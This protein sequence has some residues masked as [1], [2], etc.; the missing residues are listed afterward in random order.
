MGSTEEGHVTQVEI[1]KKDFLE[2][3]TSDRNWEG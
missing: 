3:V 2:E 1:I